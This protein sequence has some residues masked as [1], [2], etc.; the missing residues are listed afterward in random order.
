V[1]AIT[2]RYG[3]LKTAASESRRNLSGREKRDRVLDWFLLDLVHFE[4]EP[5]LA[6]RFRAQDRFE[7]E[8][9]FLL[10]ELDPLFLQH[11][12][13]EMTTQVIALE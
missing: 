10:Q 11:L 8:E 6:V 7:R 5:L 2:Q 3:T 12:R 1:L 13:T 9:R 4:R